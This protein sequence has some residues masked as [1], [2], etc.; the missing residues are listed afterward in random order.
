MPARAV[1]RQ[2]K[3][4][5]TPLISACAPSTPG[6]I[7]AAGERAM[8][9]VVKLAKTSGSP[10]IEKISAHL[11]GREGVEDTEFHVQVGETVTFSKTVSES[12]VYLFAG[13]TGDLSPHHVNK[14]YMEKS[15]YGRLIA[16]GSLLVGFMST[17]STMAIAG[18]RESDET[19]VS[20]GYDRLR[21]LKPV[22]LGDTVTVHYEIATIDPAARRSTADIKVTNQ[23][24]E[25]VAVG[26]HILKWVAN[27]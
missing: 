13:I 17:A 24:G 7:E 1:P 6:Q 3:V 27:Q 16:H 15:S 11:E 12:D 9:D 4:W 8:Q 19:P 26:Q 18:S 10:A 22:F 2:I 25:L 21:F 5:R 14:A 23:D 20:V